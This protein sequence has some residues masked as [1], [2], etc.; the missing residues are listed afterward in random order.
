MLDLMFFSTFTRSLVPAGLIWR[1]NTR[2]FVL[3]H[4]VIPSTVAKMI[5]IELFRTPFW[6]WRIYGNPNW[7]IYELSILIHF[8]QKFRTPF[9]P[10]QK[11]ITVFIHKNW[12][13]PN[14]GPRSLIFLESKNFPKYKGFLKWR[15]QNGW[16]IIENPIKKW[17]I[18]GF[19]HFRETSTYTVNCLVCPFLVV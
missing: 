13:S 5:F 8:A 10:L 2:N 12:V 9:H 7:R 17:M 15:Y 11:I 19:P 1:K 14:S 4:F 18:W 6:Q 16:F 3:G